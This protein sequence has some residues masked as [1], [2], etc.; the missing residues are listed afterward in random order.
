MGQAAAEVDQQAIAFVGVEEVIF[1]MDVSECA[2]R[3]C[4]RR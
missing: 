2:S 3:S 1:L 4:R